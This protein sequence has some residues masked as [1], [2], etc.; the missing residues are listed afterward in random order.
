[1][2]RV[3]KATEKAL[4]QH[5]IYQK[6]EIAYAIHK[7]FPFFEALRDNKFITER[8]YRFSK[9]SLEAC[10]NLVPISRVVHNVLTKLEKTFDLPLLMTLFSQS[11]LREYPDLMVIFRS[12]GSVVASYEHWSRTTPSGSVEESSLQT[13]QLPGPHPPTLSSLLCT[14]GVTELQ[15]ASE[16]I[17]KILH[18]RPSPS[19][20]ALPLPGLIQ[21]GQNSPGRKR[22]RNIWPTPKRHQKKSRPKA[23]SPEQGTQKELQAVNQ[24]TQMRDD[25]TQDLDVLERVQEAKTD[26]A[27]TPTPEEISHETSEINEGTTPQKIPST[28][29]RTTHGKDLELQ[30]SELSHQKPKSE[31]KKKKKCIWSTSR[32]RQKKRLP[33]EAASSGRGIQEKAQVVDQETQRKDNSD[34]AERAKMDCAQKATAEEKP[35]DDA[36]DFLSPTLP[37]TCGDAKG[38]LY[39]EKMQQGSSEKCIQNEE[40]TWFTPDEF[41]IEGKREK[42]KDWKKSVRCRGQTLRHLMEKRLLFCP[43]KVNMKRKVTSR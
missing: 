5:F 7:P 33:R 30:T 25:L 13:P 8:V 16:Q 6:L 15:A 42:S 38:V 19:N 34:S 11:N 14:P 37:V 21:E 10:G 12:F 2:F 17:N 43:S 24:G 3:T 23:V 29:P 28:P 20:P 35:E 26:C 9:E 27:Q 31:K 4:L 40:G 22:K 41:V 32:R 36:V 1:M 39:K 18:E